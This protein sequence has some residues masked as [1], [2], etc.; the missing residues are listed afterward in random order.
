MFCAVVKL[1]IFLV[2]LDSTLSPTSAIDNGVVVGYTSSVVFIV[3]EGVLMYKSVLLTDKEI[4]LLKT[5]LGEYIHQNLNKEAI[6]LTIILNR[7][8]DKYPHKPLIKH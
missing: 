7:L 5:V 6:N 4:C 3:K 1:D 2:L 8:R